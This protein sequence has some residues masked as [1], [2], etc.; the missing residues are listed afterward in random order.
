MLVGNK[1]AMLYDGAEGNSISH[2]RRNIGLVW[3][4]M[5]IEVKPE[6]SD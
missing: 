4:S 3:I 1:L 5:P 2:I 6:K